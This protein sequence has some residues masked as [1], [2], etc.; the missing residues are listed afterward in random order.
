MASQLRWHIPP[1]TALFLCYTRITSESV[2]ENKSAFW[3][4][5]V[6]SLMLER[7][8][9]R[10]KNAIGGPWLVSSYGETRGAMQNRFSLRKMNMNSGTRAIRAVGFNRY[11]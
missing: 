6:S 1:P 2:A 7:I 10:R 5:C 8:N 11:A 3:G 9:R 4:A